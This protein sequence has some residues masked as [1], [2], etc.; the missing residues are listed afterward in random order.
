MISFIWDCIN[1]NVYFEIKME[2]E[3]ATLTGQK[4]FLSYY[5]DTVEEW[6]QIKQIEKKSW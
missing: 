2:P 4:S 3:H 6:E 5:R 1:T